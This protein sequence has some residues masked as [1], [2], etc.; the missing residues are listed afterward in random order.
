MRYKIGEIFFLV[1]MFLV[2]ILGCA[3]VA[4]LAGWIVWAVTH[5]WTHP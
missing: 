2:C 1:W 3:A 5:S 4:F